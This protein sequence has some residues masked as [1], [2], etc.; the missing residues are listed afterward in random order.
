MRKILLS[1]RLG[2]TKLRY[3]K[4]THTGKW[5]EPNEYGLYPNGLILYHAYQLTISAPPLS[6]RLRR[7]LHCVIPITT[8]I[9]SDLRSKR[10]TISASSEVHTMAVIAQLLCIKV[11]RQ[12]I[13]DVDTAVDLLDFHLPFRHFLLKP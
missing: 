11:L 6:M 3:A 2:R 4:V 5:L 1:Q 13:R 9:S 7:L 12:V 8:L 10:M